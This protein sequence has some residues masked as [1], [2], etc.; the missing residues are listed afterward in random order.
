MRPCSRKEDGG[1]GENKPDSCKTDTGKP[2]F[3]ASEGGCFEN[4]KVSEDI[5][6]SE[7]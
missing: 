6:P 7:F 5:T 1:D 4:L 3:K 2:P